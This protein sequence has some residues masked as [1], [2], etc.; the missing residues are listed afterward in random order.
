MESF[1]IDSLGRVRRRSLKR[2]Y[3]KIRELITK[4]FSCR[5]IVEKTGADISTVKEISLRMNLSDEDKK[6]FNKRPYFSVGIMDDKKNKKKE[7]MREYIIK[8]KESISEQRRGYREKNKE[9]LNDNSTKYYS[10]NKEN[11]RE[12]WLFKSHG[13]T[14]TEYDEMYKKQKGRCAICK[15]HQNKLNIWLHVDHNHKNGKNR[16]LLCSVC[17]HALG[18]FKDN[19]TSIENAIQYLKRK[20]E[21]SLVFHKIKKISD[22]DYSHL[23]NLQGGG[24]AICGKTSNGIFKRLFED[25]DHS[26]G[27]IRGLL[28][29]DCNSGLGALKDNVLL[30]KRAIEYLRNDGVVYA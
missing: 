27:L 20:T 28:C 10:S 5:E 3:K 6:A 23:L 19:I 11:F 16:G 15:I 14:L 25:H 12:Y 30:L 7:V 2:E 17:N 8:N 21:F 1:N 24:C 26:T 13:I 18:Y 22:D 4:G 29:R 9:K